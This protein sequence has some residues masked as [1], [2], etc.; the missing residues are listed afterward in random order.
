MSTFAFMKKRLRSPSNQY[1]F[2]SLFPVG[3]SNICDHSSI[4]NSSGHFTFINT[5]CYFCTF[6]QTAYN[7]SLVCDNS[8][9]VDHICKVQNKNFLEFESLFAFFCQRYADISSS[10]RSSVPDTESMLNFYGFAIETG[11]FGTG[12]SG[13]R[14]SRPIALCSGGSSSSSRCGGS[15][16]TLDTTDSC[17][18]AAS[19]GKSCQWTASC[20]ACG[21]AMMFSGVPGLSMLF[22]ILSFGRVYRSGCD[23]SFFFTVSSLNFACK[24]DALSTYFLLV[25]FPSLF[26]CTSLT[27]GDVSFD[28]EPVCS[29]AHEK[30][31]FGS[32]LMPAGRYEVV[33][34]DVFSDCEG[35]RGHTW[36]LCDH[37]V[38]FSLT[39]DGQFSLLCDFLLQ[40]KYLIAS[41]RK[42]SLHQ[43]GWVGT[44]TAYINSN[45]F[46]RLTIEGRAEMNT[47]KK[48][49][50]FE[51]VNIDDDSIYDTSYNTLELDP[52]GVPVERVEKLVDVDLSLVSRIGGA[53]KGV[54]GLVTKCHAVWDWPLDKLVGCVDELGSRLDG[55]YNVT[56][57]TVTESGGHVPYSQFVN[58][59]WPNT[60]EELVKGLNAGFKI[61]DEN[62]EAINLAIRTIGEVFVG[63]DEPFEVLVG[64]DNALQ[65]ALEAVMKRQNKIWHQVKKLKSP[66][67]SPLKESLKALEAKIGVLDRKVTKLDATPDE[68][69][70]DA[71]IDEALRP[72]RKSLVD[73]AEV[74]ILMKEISDRLDKTEDKLKKKEDAIPTPAPTNDGGRRS[75]TYGRTLPR[76]D[77]FGQ[78]QMDSTPLTIGDSRVEMEHIDVESV[79]HATIQGG[80]IDVDTS[81]N[82]YID[83]LQ[84]LVFIDQFDWTSA[85]QV[86]TLVKEYHFPESLFKHHGLLRKSYKLFQYFSC[87]YLSIEVSVT[88]PM[89]QGGVMRMCWD[90]QS[91]ANK[92]GV[93]D[94]Y[95]LSSLPFV[96]IHASESCVQTL[97]VPFAGIQ[98]QLSLVGDEEGLLSF[99]T[100]KFFPLCG[101]IMAEGASDRCNIRVSAK[102][103]NPRF[104][105]L[106]I[107]HG[108]Q[109]KFDGL[110]FE[111]GKRIGTSELGNIVTSNL[112]H[113]GTWSAADTGVLFS[114]SV[115]PCQVKKAADRCCLTS[116]SMVASLFQYWR[117]SLIYTVTF[118]PNRLTSGKLGFVHMPAQKIM[119]AIA[120]D[121]LAGMAGVIYDASKSKPE[122]EIEVPYVGVSRR[123]LVSQSHIYD[124]MYH[125]ENVKSRLHCYVVTSLMGSLGSTSSIHYAVS[126]RPG[127]DFELSSPRGIVMGPREFLRAEVSLGIHSSDT[128]IFKLGSY[129]SVL[130]GTFGHVLSHKFTNGKALNLQVSPYWRNASVAQTPMSFLSS[131]FVRWRGSMVFE[132]HAIKGNLQKQ[133]KVM[134]FKTAEVVRED[135]AEFFTTNE[136]YPASG[137]PSISWYPHKESPY[138]VTIPYDARY[139]SLLIPHIG[140]AKEDVIPKCCYNGCLT[141]GFVGEEDLEVHITVRP[142]A[143]FELLDNAPL[144]QMGSTSSSDLVYVPT[145]KLVS[146][147]AQP[148]RRKESTR[149]VSSDPGNGSSGKKKKPDVNGNAEMAL[150]GALGGMFAG[151]ELTAA[152][153]SVDVQSLVR[154]LNSFTSKENQQMYQD[155][156]E[157]L[158]SLDVSALNV[159]LESLA[160]GPGESK[161]SSFVAT[162]EKMTGFG[163]AV[164]EFLS[165]SLNKTAPM[166]AKSLLSEG[167]FGTLLIS[168]AILCAAILWWC[169]GDTSTSLTTKMLAGL[170]VIWAPALAGRLVETLLWIKDYIFDSVVTFQSHEKSKEARSE[171]IPEGAG[172]GE[173]DLA[174]F[175]VGDSMVHILQP[176]L[177]LSMALTSLL[178]LSFLPSKAQATNFIDRFSE[179]SGRCRNMQSVSMGLKAVNDFASLFSTQITDWILWLQGK[180]RHA[181]DTSLDIL[182]NFKIMDWVKRIEELSLEENKFVDITMD[183]KVE[184]IRHL[185]DK[186]LQILEARMQYKVDAGLAHVLSLAW[187]QCTNLRNE[188]YNCV[189][190]GQY[191]VDPFHLSIYGEP[192]VGKSANAMSLMHFVLNDM[193]VPKTDR[194]YARNPQDAYWSR[195]YRQPVVMYDD[196]GSIVGSP[197]QSDYGELIGL[198]SNNPYPLVMAAVEEKGKLFA[199][200]LIVSCT[201]TRM[202]DERSNLRCKEAY[203]RRRNLLVSVKR[204][205][206]VPINPKDPSEGVL[207]TVLDSLTGE[208]KT[209]WTEFFCPKEDGFVIR[210]WKFDRFSVFLSDYA[211]KYLKSQEQLVATMKANELGVTEHLPKDI[212]YDIM[213]DL[214]ERIK[215]QLQR[216]KTMGI[217]ESQM[218]DNKGHKVV[219][220]YESLESMRVRVE[221]LDLTP[222]D[223]V[224]AYK[225]LGHHVELSLLA[226]LHHID[227][228]AFVRPMCDC[229]ELPQFA[230][231]SDVLYRSVCNFAS[232]CRAMGVN[233]VFV[234]G[235]LRIDYRE[236]AD[237]H[238]MV[239]SA[240]FLLALIISIIWATHNG[241]ARCPLKTY[242]VEGEAKRAERI[243]R[244]KVVPLIYTEERPT[245]FELNHSATME[246]DGMLFYPWRGVDKAFPSISAVVGGIILFDD[247]KFI[248]V[249]PYENFEAACQLSYEDRIKAYRQLVM[250]TEV[251]EGDNLLNLLPCEDLLFCRGTLQQ[252][253]CL[254][255]YADEIEKSHVVFEEA[256]EYFGGRT[257]CYLIW[258]LC[259]MNMTRNTLLRSA[260]KKQA[261]ER[262]EKYVSKLEKLHK[263]EESA[264]L[265]CSKGYKFALTAGAVVLGVAG[266][267]GV[268]FSLYKVFTTLFGKEEEPYHTM[269]LE[270]EMPAGLNSGDFRTRHKQSVRKTAL[271]RRVGARGQMA[272]GMNSGDYKTKHAK[273][274]LKIQRFNPRKGLAQM[275]CATLAGGTVVPEREVTALRETYELDESEFDPCEWISEWQQWF[276]DESRIVDP[277]IAEE[278][279]VRIVGSEF[280]VVHSGDL[281]TAVPNKVIK[282]PREFMFDVCKHSNQALLGK[283]VAFCRQQLHEIV[284]QE[285]LPGSKES[286]KSRTLAVSEMSDPNT[287]AL[288]D[289]K[290][291]KACAQLYFFEGNIVV[292]ALRVIGG[293]ILIPAHYIKV[294]RDGAK[295]A[296]A[297]RGHIRRLEFYHGNCF[298]VSKH[299]DVVLYNCG[300]RVPAAPSIID[301]F[302]NLED[303]ANFSQTSGHMIYNTFA[304]SGMTV[305]IEKLPV[306][307]VVQPDSRIAT[308]YYKLAEP[309]ECGKAEPL[310]HMINFGVQYVAETCHGMCG[311]V[312]VRDCPQSP[313]KLVGIHI[314]SVAQYSVGYA[315]II[316]QESL[317]RVIYGQVDGPVTIDGE[318][319]AEMENLSLRPFVLENSQLIRAPTKLPV[320]GMLSAEMC[321][322]TQVRSDIVPSPINALIGEPQSE[323]SVLSLWDRRLDQTAKGGPNMVGKLDVLLDA[324]EK[325]GETTYEFPATK[326]LAVEFHLKNR[327]AQM[328]NSL[329]RRQ[330]LSVEEAINGVD[331]T[332]FWKQLDMSTSCGYPYT[333]ERPHGATGKKWCFI[334]DGSYPSGKTRYIISHQPL[335]ERINARLERAR[336][337]KR[338]PTLIVACPKDERR[339]LSKIY[340]K[341]A[342]RSFSNLPLDLNI[343]FRMYFLDF[344]VMMMERRNEHF[345]KVGINP[346]SMEWTQLYQSLIEKSDRGFAGDYA[347]F[348]G[349]GPP[350]I[351]ASITNLI[352]CWY[353]DGA[354]NA[355]VRHV[356][357]MEAFSNLSLVRDCVVEIAQGIPS[358]FP[359]TVIFNCIVNYYFLG[360]AW[361]DIVG[362]SCYSEYATVGHFDDLCGVATYG[363]DNVVSVH[364]DLLQTFNLRSF[365]SWLKEYGVGYTDDKK[366]PIEL[367][368]AHVAIADVSFLKRKFVP[369]PGSSFIMSAPL[370]QV[371]IEEQVHWIRESDDRFEALKQNVDNALFEASIHGK[372]Y[373]EDL[374]GRINCAMDAIMRAGFVNSFEEQRT[375]WWDA[376]TGGRVKTDVLLSY[377]R[378]GK[379]PKIYS[380]DVDEAFAE[381]TLVKMAEAPSQRVPAFFTVYAT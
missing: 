169:K 98:T 215:A 48:L 288:L 23:G 281:F 29:I 145:N 214:E 210:D 182:V 307:R 82:L 170:A 252:L 349:I 284:V 304:E 317:K 143:D 301:L 296:M 249:G 166:Y 221:M 71:K 136:T 42:C 181:A 37:R 338:F 144:K 89:T 155:L 178:G 228:L 195:Y 257:G 36:R 150:L 203:L 229:E 259:H 355:R 67:F 172:R 280:T 261:T 12:R 298:F 167:K 183:E 313:R 351:Y 199:S 33:C 130:L 125:G 35:H 39:L 371:S 84:S 45:S 305:H 74:P 364:P 133:K 315:E 279:H 85:D 115:H 217:G 137:Q 164:I 171:P 290:L 197:D 69:D 348:D 262:K 80:A 267:A 295:F 376:H 134:F 381:L 268:A 263:I 63:L 94:G 62:M 92:M 152:A 209:K 153:K 187:K 282:C 302:I 363:D 184:E 58:E 253:E 362:E 108:I 129:D 79:Q 251:W 18:S 157:K 51:S 242:I 34:D 346:C 306:V 326:I 107:P 222:E 332:D 356:L 54:A 190:L 78:P 159:V 196:L 291:R 239:N 223:V 146:V 258:F 118:G 335:T 151:P 75:A 180:G 127:P 1:I 294:L 314:A 218:C 28:A 10:C 27:I 272:S 300:A 70:V 121:D 224:D 248:F 373:F 112:V 308:T 368:D 360:M 310:I 14:V 374:K 93:K 232:T 22:S 156:A 340:D 116:L 173:I 46:R 13:L 81:K 168:G 90:S 2:T 344:G 50:D 283:E 230:C 21:T 226:R 120:V 176:F 96:H 350:E 369:M 72:I 191:R 377:I 219:H 200:N 378:D 207:Y 177:Y 161:P 40:G 337:G 370:E 3:S 347:K 367:S 9:L 286:L 312:I 250:G 189:G 61:H 44:T 208:V 113:H 292:Q 148:V 361:I 245:I 277:V 95:R 91:C 342:T 103:I 24:L 353:N 26:D 380:V 359:M 270:P 320:V 6:I 174:S 88:S 106:T 322:K 104:K 77:A 213:G 225:Q 243:L 186:G 138:T 11:I 141:A 276:L 38:G 99:G 271:A 31:M 162:M 32:N 198:K 30:G 185:Y 341:P 204:D 256:R 274:S 131:L 299:Q 220:M 109:G 83:Y 366:N 188:T 237:A 17:V 216:A 231:I 352:N 372:P 142:G 328:Q 319:F 66:D 324:V 7:I 233:W 311:A 20:T 165:R 60:I 194:F 126:V 266:A 147:E 149:L 327:F 110:G 285:A 343:V 287:R 330:V 269:D 227:I 244:D 193:G 202:I 358:G 5:L 323:R 97:K 357:V 303:V 122:I 333:V 236:C 234:H 309:E 241:L 68:M 56:S 365:A 135:A 4:R 124:I 316:S 275:Q 123:D 264:F 49:M 65:E 86:C 158:S 111:A 140:Y 278:S 297:F 154:S 87:D 206:N 117:G 101:L 163:E 345:M 100:L 246:V 211:Q 25:F 289:G 105:T 318:G 41:S 57:S 334:E 240:P 52:Y 247:C 119:D 179:F 293:W 128:F 132:F 8:C 260:I 73:F 255:L 43:I 175:L 19:D 336:N 212:N 53:V 205:S 329:N 47:S 59:V 325:Y 238:K 339:K 265:E 379:S 15:E 375:R 16:I 114:L 331:G 76:F 254:P 273:R 102:V 321:P 64:N 201:N 160:K 235:Q 139:D 354:E 192:G 55:T